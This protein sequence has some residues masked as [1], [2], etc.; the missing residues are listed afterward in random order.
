VLDDET[1]RK[2]ERCG[3]LLSSIQA[4][5][6]GGDADQQ[7]SPV[8]V[9]HAA[10]FLADEDSPSSSAGSK[11]AIDFD[12][13]RSPRKAAVVSDPAEDDE[14]WRPT[15]TVNP[16]YSYVAELVR[17][18]HG[19]KW[20]D[21]AY[22]YEIAEQRRRRLHPADAD[23]QCH[24]RR[25]LCG[26]VAEALERQRSA[27]PWDPASWLRGGELLDHVW[28]EVRRARE[29]VSAEG[30]NDVTCSA[31]VRCDLRRHPRRP[32]PE[33]ADAVL[34]IERLVFKDLVVDTIR[35]LDDADRLLMPRRRLVF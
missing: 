32:G 20:R 8:S 19:G 16:D 1:N 4:F 12:I 2:L 28:A 10:S 18:F 6:G 22:V 29:P 30:L 3:K 9:L 31:A 27:C 33:V 25:L 34:H 13:A 17:L 24:H 35:E 15:V 21:P 23:D 14:S 11:R 5:T 26:A 7:P